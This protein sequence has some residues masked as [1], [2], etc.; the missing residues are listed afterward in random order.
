MDVRLDSHYPAFRR[1]ITLLYP[2]FKNKWGKKIVPEEWKKRLLVKITK[3][4]GITQRNKWRGL[5]LLSVP[6]KVLNQIILSRI[7]SVI[8]K[9]LR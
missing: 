3:K 2:L 1:Y 9:R 6:S 5:T 7:K 4:G 8:E